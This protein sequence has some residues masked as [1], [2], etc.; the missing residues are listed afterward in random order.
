VRPDSG[1]PPEV[2]LKTAIL[3]DRAFGSKANGKGYR[4]LNHVRIIQGDGIN[5][6][7]IREIL[8]NLK[9]NGYSAENVAFGMGGALLQQVHRDTQKFAMKCSAIRINGVWHDAFKDPVTD[10]GK[11]SKR[12]RMSLLRFRKRNEFTIARREAES[13]Y[14]AES[15]EMLQP[16]WRNGALL[17]DQTLAEIRSRSEDVGAFAGPA[18]AFN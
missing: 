10:P 16:V 17:R 3:L 4:V 13:A 14:D 12:G 5:I 9:I 6:R 15:E 18:W 1:N 7:S 2:V 8:S 11:A